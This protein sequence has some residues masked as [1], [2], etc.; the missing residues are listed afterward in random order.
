VRLVYD[1]IELLQVT[2]ARP[3]VTGYYNKN[4]RREGIERIGIRMASKLRKKDT[5]RVPQAMGKLFSS[6]AEGMV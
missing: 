2:T 1:P 5:G 6:N 4:L 3:E